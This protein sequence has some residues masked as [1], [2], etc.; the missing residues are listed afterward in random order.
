[1]AIIPQ[2]SVNTD[3]SEGMCFGCGKSNAIGLKL[4]FRR[5]GDEVRAEF[6]PGSQYQSWPGMVHGGIVICML[7]EAMSYAAYFGGFTCITA[8]L[9]ARLKQM[10]PIGEPLVITS[11]I[12]RYTRKLVDTRAE[13]RLQ[14]GT[15]AAE[16]TSTQ[17][18]VEDKADG[19][20]KTEGN[21]AGA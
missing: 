16:G 14:D 13:I 2:V 20:S 11:S 17:F 3:L 18:F 8:K 10:V 6:T 4:E 5:E 12:T 19:K 1:M 21:Q 15:V 7:D 9:E